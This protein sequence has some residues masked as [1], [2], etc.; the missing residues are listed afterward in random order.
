MINKEFNKDELR[1]AMK[2]QYYS[3]K[4][5]LVKGKRV[6]FETPVNGQ[7]LSKLIYGD[8]PHQDFYAEVWENFRKYN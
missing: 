1:R 5:I 6:D 3:K 7:S 4:D 2:K 8:I